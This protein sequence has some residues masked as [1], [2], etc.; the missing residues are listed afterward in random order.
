MVAAYPHLG[1]ARP[2][3]ASEM[4][5]I[6]EPPYLLLYRLINEGVQIVRILH[7]AW[8]IAAPLSSDVAE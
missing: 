4:R 3:L 7:G 5:M 6:V 2:D 8:H 1:R